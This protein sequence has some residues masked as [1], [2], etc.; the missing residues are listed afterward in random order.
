M[1]ATK[2]ARP[3][4]AAAVP[5][6]AGTRTDA[7]QPNAAVTAPIVA[8]APGAPTR[9]SGRRPLIV[10]APLAVAVAGGAAFWAMLRG[11]EDGSYNPRGVPS[12]LIGRKAP[13]TPLP[14]VEGLNLPPISA[15]TLAA[16]G[17]PILVNFWA[18]WCVPCVQ[19]HPQLMALQRRNVPIYGVNHKDRPEAASG[20]LTRHGN[21]FTA[22]S[23]DAGRT[24][25]EWGVYG[26]PETYLLDKDGIVRWRWAGPIMPDTVEAEL[27]PL[28]RRHA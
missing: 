6:A 21:P 11:M 19:E 5:S 28:L 10:L 22:I 23:A 24:G 15:E 7:P 26:V 16:P 1:S 3:R 12:V 4:G 25:I 8:T 18:S 27:N 9:A 17:R 2:D 14:P 20:F 13:Q